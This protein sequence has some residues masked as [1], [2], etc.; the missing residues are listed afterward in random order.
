MKRILCVML[1]LIFTLMS[2]LSCTASTIDINSEG[3]TVTTYGD[4]IIEKIENDTRWNLDSYIGEEEE[5][6]VPRFISNL[7]VVSLGHHAFANNTT[8]KSVVTSSPLWDIGEYAFI[9]CTALESFE[10]H[11]VLKTIGTGAF[12]GT[13]SLTDINLETSV[14]TTVSDYAFADSGLI[15]VALPETCT[16]IGNYAFVRCTSL[17]RIDIPDSVTEIADT[18]FAGCESLVFYCTTDSYAHEYAEAKGIPY[19]LT[20]APVEHT[21]IVGDTDG[22][23]TVTIIDATKIQRLLAGLVDDPDGMMTLRAAGGAEL[24]IMHATRIQRWL[25]GYS[26]EG[27]V[28]DTVTV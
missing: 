19:V 27:G 6:I 28:G 20:D 11:Y 3:K 10:C 17:E 13:A 26:V 25:A 22:D 18:A 7:L 8:V 14:I 23:G 24:N 15:T 21:F 2:V 4:W 16:S 12:S 9:D 5:V 1:V